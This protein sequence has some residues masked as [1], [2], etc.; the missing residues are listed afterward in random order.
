MRKRGKKK[1][2][3]GSGGGGSS[4]ALVVEKIKVEMLFHL[5]TFFL[6][7]ISC[8]RAFQMFIQMA[9]SVFGASKLGR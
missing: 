3:A 8:C 4:G 5:A 1:T 7:N 6:K 9:F 2:T